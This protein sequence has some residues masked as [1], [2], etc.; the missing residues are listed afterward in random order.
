ME[1]FTR[2]PTRELRE[3]KSLTAE[4]D[5]FEERPVYQE[6]FDKEKKV[7]VRLVTNRDMSLKKPYKVTGIQDVASNNNWKAW[8][9]LAP[10]L[11]L[12]IVFLVYPLINTIF[13]AFLKN[14]DYITGTFDGVTLK[15]FGVIFGLTQYNG[16]YETHFVKYAIP[17][18]FLIVLVTVPL[19]TIIALLIS[20]GLNKIRFLQKFFQIVFFLPYVTNAIAVGM[21]FAVMF[22][23]KGIINFI[24]HSNTA[25]VYGATTAHAFLPLCFYIIW[26]SLPFKILIFLSGLQ[27]IDKEYYNAAKMDGA[28]GTKTLWKITVPLM[29]PQI[30]YIMV[31]SLIG[32]FKEYTAI[33]GLFNGPGTT[34]GDYN[35]YTVVYYIYD[36]LSTHTSFAAAAAVFLFL[37]ILFFTFLQL[38][39][40]KKRIH[41]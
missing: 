29:G 5:F 36:N 35:M 6:G 1:N 21:V 9:Y 7:I 38:G 18:T 10:I 19:S 37:V 27:G 13:I 4:N 12:L 26:S 3:S 8:L 33:V 16:V 28:S 31:T 14:Y 24:F 30:L 41:Y 34:A 25:W 17:N 20:V 23:Q 11:V 39:V 40:S 22:D 32:A 15:N 2:D